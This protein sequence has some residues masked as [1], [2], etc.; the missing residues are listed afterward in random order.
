MRREAKM[1]STLM[2]LAMFL[3][4]AGWGLAQ[5]PVGNPPDRIMVWVD[6]EGNV[7]P[8]KTP[9]R[10]YFG[11]RLSPDG[12]Q[13]AIEVQGP[14]SQIWTY[15]I[16]SGKGTQII[17]AGERLIIH[18]P[19]GGGYGDPKARDR[20]QVRSDVANEL[21]SAEAASELYGFSK[22]QE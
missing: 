12:R 21:I 6:R 5:R 1:T 19:G 11:P 9:A 17:R 15:D 4:T 18:T 10:P 13:V 3:M 8:L 2:T 22:D 14:R 16:A 20:E 7:E